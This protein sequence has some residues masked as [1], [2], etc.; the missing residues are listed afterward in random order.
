MVLLQ[1]QSLQGQERAFEKQ[2]DRSELRKHQWLHFSPA[3]GPGGGPWLCR[4]TRNRRKRRASRPCSQEASSTRPRGLLLLMRRS[5]TNQVA[6]LTPVPE[7]RV[8]W[9]PPNVK[10]DGSQDR[11]P[12]P[13]PGHRF[14]FR[15]RNFW[16][17]AWCCRKSQGWERRRVFKSWLL[18]LP[19]LG[20]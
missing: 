19:A 12:F 11:G 9:P 20:L 16:A 4:S 17:A 5:P 3:A 7:S 18:Y 8:L 6:E 10:F 14:T 15:W 13:S 1:V 2:T